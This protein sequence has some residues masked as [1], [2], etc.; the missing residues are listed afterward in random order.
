MEIA[1]CKPKDAGTYQVTATNEFGTETAPVTLIITQNPDDVVDPKTK[2]K[3]RDIK[4]RAAADDGPEWGKLRKAGLIK[5]PDDDGPDQIKLRHVEREKKTAEEVE[6]E[7]P[8]EV[9]YYLNKSL[10]CILFN[11]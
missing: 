1:N 6:K 5:K 3:N 9:D 10:I 4:R 7:K 11:E 2:L 8:V